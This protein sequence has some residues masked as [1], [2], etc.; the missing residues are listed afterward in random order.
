MCRALIIYSPAGPWELVL[1]PRWWRGQAGTARQLAQDWGSEWEQ[2]QPDPGSALC[3]FWHLH[4]SRNEA[5][6]A[7]FWL[8]AGGSNLQ[9]RASSSWKLAHPP[10]SKDEE[11]A[12]TIFWTSMP[13]ANLPH[14]P[15]PSPPLPQASL[16]QLVLGWLAELVLNTGPKACSGPWNWGEASGHSQLLLLLR[17]AFH[18]VKWTDFSEQFFNFL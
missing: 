11:N 14:P 10:I 4:C 5:T 2:G 16:L 17:Y 1:P 9:Q 3:G 7:R 15:A 12:G 13:V 8:P 18:T 6:V